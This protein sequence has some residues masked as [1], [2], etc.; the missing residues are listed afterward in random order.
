M[1]YPI[2]FGEEN[3]EFRIT[4]ISDIKCQINVSLQYNTFGFCQKRIFDHVDLDN[5]SDQNQYQQGVKIKM[6][7][8]PVNHL[9]VTQQKLNSIKTTVT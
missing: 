7:A 9:T 1:T 5:E 8:N 6:S 3:F 2:I 4:G